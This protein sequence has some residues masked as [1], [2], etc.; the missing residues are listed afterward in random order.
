MRPFRSVASRIEKK[1]R[2]SLNVLTE[3][4]E[5]QASIWLVAWSGVLAAAFQ[6][7]GLVATLKNSK[8]QGHGIAHG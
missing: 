4:D 8:I 2:G 3:G 1:P 5:S 7:R 6:I